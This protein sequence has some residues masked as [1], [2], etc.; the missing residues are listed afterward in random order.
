MSSAANASIAQSVS[1]LGSSVANFFPVTQGISALT[2][3]NSGLAAQRAAND[4]A[5]L[6]DRQADIVLS[7]TIRDADR[8]RRDVITFRESQAHAFLDSGVTLQ[9]SPMEI[10]TETVRKGNAQIEALVRRG[11]AES[12]LQRD[13][14]NILR[15]SGAF[16]A[17]SAVQSANA[18]LANSWILGSRI[19]VFGNVP[20]SLSRGST[21]GISNTTTFNPLALPLPQTP[22]S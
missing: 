4:E 12:D 10:L 8:L 18:S 3:I 2:Q 22:G 13:K 9:G 5:E 16:N 17:L 20:T 15:R 21:P 6:M 7:E 11:Q 1:T 14:A 19:G